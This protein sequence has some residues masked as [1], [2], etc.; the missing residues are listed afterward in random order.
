MPAVKTLTIW[1]I[2][3]EVV[4]SLI[5]TRSVIIVNG[6]GAVVVCDDKIVCDLV[7]VFHNGRLAFVED[8]CEHL[9]R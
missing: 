5:I 4:V 3:E 7:V 6:H 2:G 9:P 8:E 1:G